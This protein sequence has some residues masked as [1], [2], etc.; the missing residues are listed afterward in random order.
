MRKSVKIIIAMIMTMALA[1]GLCACGGPSDEQ[2]SQIESKTK[3]CR[4]LYEESAVLLG[5]IEDSKYYDQL[6]DVTPGYEEMVNQFYDLED[7]IKTFENAAKNELDSLD[8]ESADEFIAGLDK[9]IKALKTS[10][11][12]F[13]KAVDKLE[14]I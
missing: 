4:A 7:S 3:Q 2:K 13:Q 12:Q 8:P 11:G 9:S 1:I 6:L 10:K 14:S 5:E